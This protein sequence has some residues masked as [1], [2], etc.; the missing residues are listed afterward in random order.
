MKFVLKNLNYLN[1]FLLLTII[2]GTIKTNEAPAENPAPEGDAPADGAPANDAAAPAEG[3][4]AAAPAEGGD[5][6]APAE[7]EEAKP[8]ESAFPQIPRPKC[9]SELVRAFGM[10]GRVH[11][12]LQKI[13]FCPF[14]K[15]SCCRLKD[16]LTMYN[17]WKYGG[18]E[19]LI[20]DRFM[21]VE[22]V[23]MRYVSIMTKIKTRAEAG[24]Q[25]N[26]NQK[27]SNCNLLASRIVKFEIDDLQRQIRKNLD[28][29]KRFML[30]SY[31]GF[32]CSIC[33]F[34]NHKFFNIEEKILR[35]DDNFCF[36]N[37]SNTLPTL[38]FFH[39]DINDY[40]NIVSQYMMSCSAD[41]QYRFELEIPNVMKFDDNAEIITELE[42]C[43]DNIDNDHWLTHC[44]FICDQFSVVALN[45][46]FEPQLDKIELYI[47][48]IKAKYQEKVIE[49]T[50][51]F[52][53]RS[54]HK[55]KKSLSDLLVEGVGEVVKDLSKD[56]KKVNKDPETA[57]TN[58]IL[59]AEPKPDAGA[60]PKEGDK[61]KDGAAPKEGD[62]PK[63]GA[64]PKEGD[65]PKEGGETPGA[66]A[67][68][69]GG[70]APIEGTKREDLVIFR[71]NLNNIFPLEDFKYEYYDVG[72]DFF[73][74]GRNC[75][76]EHELYIQVK[77]LLHLG[78]V[79]KNKANILNMF[80]KHYGG[81][82]KK[83]EGIFAGALLTVMLVIMSLI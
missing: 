45:P 82:R 58:R 19:R 64:A 36:W 42:S 80:D 78:N 7:G 55:K 27:V 13:E 74:W 71:N 3:G 67:I 50:V 28:S 40:N 9:N 46:F 35:V 6:A 49:E 31:K 17:A 14:V 24:L 73:T 62:K 56:I 53:I 79:M 30:E 16:Q 12:S 44:R 59:S 34:D 48:W 26:L 10:Q 72:L 43:Q 5:A 33:D 32:Y 68:P 18:Q 57:P 41:H 23:Y 76:F 38:L 15:R 20:K 61:P 60:A 4:D 39:K 47:K 52:D 66:P 29:V 65:K 81:H 2:T 11:P 1:L 37:V 69:E 22:K 25:N 21:H 75:L 51:P 8:L 70:E 54:K 77:G 63:D 83:N